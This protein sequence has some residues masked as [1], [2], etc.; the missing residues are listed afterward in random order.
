[1]TGLITGLATTAAIVAAMV[2]EV[3]AVLDVEEDDDVG[4]VFEA[5]LGLLVVFDERLSLRGFFT[6]LGIP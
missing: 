3:D 1:M 2:D 4:G 5:L 6:R